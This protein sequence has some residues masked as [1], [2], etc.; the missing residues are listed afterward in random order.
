MAVGFIWLQGVCLNHDIEKFVRCGE[1]TLNGYT[2]RAETE[3][4]L[5]L[6]SLSE[7]D[8]RRRYISTDEQSNCQVWK[9]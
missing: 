1:V 3:N 4:R 9:R 7:S 2:S 8:W 6:M 5:R